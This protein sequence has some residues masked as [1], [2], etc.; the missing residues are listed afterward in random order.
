MF[1][2]SDV[3]PGFRVAIA[4]DEPRFLFQGSAIGSVGSLSPLT[5]LDANPYVRV[6]NAGRG[7]ELCR[8]VGR[9]GSYC[10]YQCPSGDWRYTPQYPSGPCTPFR[11]RGIGDLPWGDSR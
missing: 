10:L 8:G 1:N 6:A 4:N 2:V 7:D 11:M 3:A 5:R 9:A